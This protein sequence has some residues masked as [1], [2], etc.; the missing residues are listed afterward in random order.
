[1]AKTVIG[2]VVIAAL[3]AAGAGAWRA[4]ARPPAEAS[5][6]GAVEVRVGDLRLTVAA[7]GKLKPKEFLSVKPKVT[8]T[9]E[10]TVLNI[11]TNG[12]VVKKG[13]LLVAFDKADLEQAISKLKIDVQSAQSELVQAKEE[14]SKAELDRELNTRDK[15]FKLM[16]A[17]KDLEKFRDL[18]REKQLKESEMK[19]QRAEANL[20]EAKKNHQESLEMRKEDLV[21]ES[22]VKK[23]SYALRDAEFAL[24]SERLS[25]KMLETYTLPIETKRLEQTLED[26]RKQLESIKPYMESIVLQKRAGVAKSERALNELQEQLK[27]KEKDLLAAEILAPA[28]GMVHYGSAS[29]HH[30]GRERESYKPGD[31]VN[32]HEDLMYIP[33]LSKM[34]LEV[35]IDEVDISK[36]RK[37]QRLV[38]YAEAHPE[39]RLE[40]AVEEV[41]QVAAK[42][43]WWETEMRFR[44]RCSL[45]VSLDWFRPDLT[46]RVEIG[47][48]DV[49]AVPLVPL[50]AVFQRDGKT[51]CYLEDGTV[52]PVTLGSS[53]NDQVQVKEGLR[54]G[55]RVRITAPASK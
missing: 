33:D 26:A 41:S 37:G 9:S 8:T 43:M 46:A 49:T 32:I 39:V 51:V 12:T 5:A 40:G 22:E 3:A 18:D 23:A 35:M 52:R 19:F 47:V 48:G 34:Y 4:G 15:S 6:A 2:I 45:D 36:I 20:E 44:V 38:A 17:E 25:R 54:P 30:W 55:E 14:V 42:D 13:D 24:E 28:D 27:K 10:L 11:V 50:D 1:M 31:K 16:L 53:T 7:E 29:G 21:A